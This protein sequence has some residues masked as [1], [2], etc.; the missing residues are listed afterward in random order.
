MEVPVF[1]SGQVLVE[2]LLESVDKFNDVAKLESVRIK[3]RFLCAFDERF[4]LFN[5]RLGMF[6]V[7]ANHVLA[8]LRNGRQ[9]D[10]LEGIVNIDSI[11]IEEQMRDLFE[12]RKHVL[13]LGITNLFDVLEYVV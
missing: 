2:M 12:A 4:D 5:Q 3:F 1:E 13:E 10:S 9:L 11:F 7:F 6:Q 8:V